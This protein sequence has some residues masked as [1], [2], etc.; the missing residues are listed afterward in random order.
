VTGTYTGRDSKIG[1]CQGDALNLS[2]AKPALQASAEP[3]FEPRAVYLVVF[4]LDRTLVS[5]N[6]SFSFCRY[7]VAK[8]VLPLS[9]LLHSCCYYLRH[10]FF[11]MSLLDL[12]AKVFEHLLKGNPL[13]W[14]ESHVTAFL[15][16]YLPTQMYLPAIAELRRAQH[17]GHY[18]LILSNSPS[19]LVEKISHMLDVD[20]WRA[21]RY[22]VDRE[23]NLCHIASVMEGEEKASCVREIAARLSISK[24]RI[25]AYSDS[26]HDLPLLLSVGTPVA[27]NP[28]RK[29]RQ[30]SLERHWAIL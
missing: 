29:L 7:L 1:R 22:A 30:F 12:H 2:Q 4:D 17:L 27:V 11:G 15:Q 5:S 14:F 10:V 9:S 16:G 28:D 13:S 19:F 20:E 8:G 21:T 3:I 6:C 26:I 24:E 25:A 23:K 18:T